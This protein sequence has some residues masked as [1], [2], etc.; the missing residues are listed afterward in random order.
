MSGWQTWITVLGG[1]GVLGALG[2]LARGWWGWHTGS[3][4]RTIAGVRDAIDAMGEAA[5]WASAYYRAREW[6]EN[7]HGFC[8]DYPPPPPDADKGVTP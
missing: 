8:L 7:L 2:S 3:S 6:C 5:R 1:A 4:Q